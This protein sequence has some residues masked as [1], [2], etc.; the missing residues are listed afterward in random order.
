MCA[1]VVIFPSTLIG[2]GENW[3]LPSSIHATQFLLFE[4]GKFSKSKGIGIFGDDVKETNIPVLLNK[5]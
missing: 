4:T 2:T 5:R 1:V 3:T